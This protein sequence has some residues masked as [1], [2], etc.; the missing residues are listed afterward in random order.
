MRA[1]TSLPDLGVTRQ[2]E[3]LTVELWNS[4]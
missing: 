1:N 2:F 3:A 4:T